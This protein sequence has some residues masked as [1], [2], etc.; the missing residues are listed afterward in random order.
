MFISPQK[1]WWLFLAKAV[2]VP[3]TWFALLIWA[4]VN[5]DPNSG[6]LA[7]TAE[8]SGSDLSWAW[9]GALNSVLGSMG[10]NIPHFTVG[11]DLPYHIASTTQVRQPK[12]RD[13]PRTQERT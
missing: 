10:V 6:L 5:G 12:T 2:I 11:H 8:I 1:I 13:I 7:Q 3:P 4:F 9:L